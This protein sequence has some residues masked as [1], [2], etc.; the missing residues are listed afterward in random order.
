MYLSG[1]FIN[2]S[3]LNPHICLAKEVHL[4][5]LGNFKKQDISD[6]PSHGQSVGFLAL[7][8]LPP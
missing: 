2:L 4:A 6:Y 7:P 8:I 5:E 3:S 1:T